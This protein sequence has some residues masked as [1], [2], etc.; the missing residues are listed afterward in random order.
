VRSTVSPGLD[1]EALH[2]DWQRRL[3]SNEQRAV[4]REGHG[5]VEAT[6]NANGD[7]EDSASSLLASASARIAPGTMVHVE[8]PQR[9][10]SGDLPE[11]GTGRGTDGART[12]IDVRV[13]ADAE[14]VSVQVKAFALVG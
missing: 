11:A 3:Y 6:P 2:F 14:T 4:S 10:R 9:G 12:D 8:A 13:G 5:D 1:Q 7:S